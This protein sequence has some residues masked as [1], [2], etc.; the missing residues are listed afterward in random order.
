MK[1]GEIRNA[2]L[3]FQKAQKI[4]PHSDEITENLIIFYR[5]FNKLKKAY[6]LI[7]RHINYNPSAKS[8]FL[9]IKAELLIGFGNFAEGCSFLNELIKESLE[10]SM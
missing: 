1:M 9:E 7:K 5:T 6:S 2:E 8:K 10:I 3:A 4:N